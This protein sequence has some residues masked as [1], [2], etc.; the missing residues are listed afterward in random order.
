MRK[1]FL[2]VKVAAGV[3][4]FLLL[5]GFAVKNSDSVAVRYFLGLEW[6]APLVFVLLVFFAVGVALG[7]AASLGI[8]V[9]QRRQI[10]RLKREL[11]GVTRA[12]APPLMAESV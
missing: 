3:A 11:R 8:I 2:L 10:L 9:G 12:A 6:Q 7:V 1:F 5:L 4:V